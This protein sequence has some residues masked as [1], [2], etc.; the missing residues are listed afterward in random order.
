MQIQKRNAYLPGLYNL[1][2]SSQD[3][4]GQTQRHSGLENSK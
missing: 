4:P 2:K 1:I 3:G